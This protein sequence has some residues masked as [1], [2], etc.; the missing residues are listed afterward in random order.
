MDRERFPE[1]IEVAREY[2]L[3][4]IKRI[5]LIHLKPYQLGTSLPE[6]IVQISLFWNWRVIGFPQK[7][8]TK[9]I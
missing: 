4:E 6:C 2:V 9:G 7:M 5:L 1:F 8:K 3:E